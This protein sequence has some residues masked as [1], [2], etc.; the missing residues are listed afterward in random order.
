MTWIIWLI[1]LTA[2]LVYSI[3]NSFLYVNLLD[4]EAIL[5]APGQACVIVKLLFFLSIVSGVNPG[6][7]EGGDESGVNVEE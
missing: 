5:F 4:S 6:F 1:R 2:T 7:S 3:Y